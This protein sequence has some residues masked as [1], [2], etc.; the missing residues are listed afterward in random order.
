MRKSQT[1]LQRDYVE[2]APVMLTKLSSILGKCEVMRIPT[3][4]PNTR[5]PNMVCAVIRKRWIAHRKTVSVMEETPG[6]K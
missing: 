4:V 3:V 6:G 1:P 2:R 5:I